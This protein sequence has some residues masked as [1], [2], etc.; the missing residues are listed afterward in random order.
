MARGAR[1]CPFSLCFVRDHYSEVRTLAQR[2]LGCPISADDLAHEVFEKLPR[3]LRRFRYENLVRSYLLSVTVRSAR[4][5]LRAAR[6]RRMPRG[7]STATHRR[8][9]V[10][11][12]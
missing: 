10:A 4:S 11:A 5:H 2:L 8:T 1:R 7:R 12:S 3:A 6:R 9:A